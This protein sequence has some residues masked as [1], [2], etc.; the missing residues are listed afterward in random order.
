MLTQPIWAGFP[1][2]CSYASGEASSLFQA[3]EGSLSP[4]SLVARPW[5]FFQDFC[6][7][8][9]KNT[10]IVLQTHWF[11]VTWVQCGVKTE[12]DTWIPQINGCIMALHVCHLA[13]VWSETSSSPIQASCSS[14][15]LRLEV[16]SLEP[17]PSVSHLG[18]IPVCRNA[19]VVLH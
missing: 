10:F 19:R 18:W 5:P 12:I 14:S 8:S 3:E 4:L 17:Q 16:L 2:L 9:G 11:L 13:L 1:D 6:Y 15:L 7:F